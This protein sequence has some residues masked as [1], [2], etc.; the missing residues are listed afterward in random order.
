M[1][2][3]STFMYLPKRN[4]NTC[5]GYTKTYNQ[6]LILA[7]FIIAKTIDNKQIVVESYNGLPCSSQMEQT[8][9]T[10]KKWMNLKNIMHHVVKK[11]PGIVVFILYD[12]IS[13]KH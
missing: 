13:V 8:A 3:Y 6:R 5:P 1:T 11:K 2:H 12:S 7:L 4:E 10:S 9:D